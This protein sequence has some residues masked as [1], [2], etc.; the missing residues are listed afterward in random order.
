MA[1]IIILILTGLLLLVLEFFV[2]PGITIAGI[3]GVIMIGSG[4]YIG[5]SKY[6]SSTGNIIVAITLLALIVVI[7][8]ALRSRT[9]NKLMLNTTITG[10]IE[11][12]S[13]SLIHAGDKG[14][15]ITRLNPIGNVRVNGQEV[16]A[17][18]PGNFVD[19]QTPVEIV[20]VYKT[21]VVVKPIN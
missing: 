1:I 10:S 16:E 21:Y 9:W 6:G 14:I 18:C 3:G 4:V 17:R 11:T 5:Y 13:E 7:G 20:K 19:A 8:I 2:L 15:A 12:V